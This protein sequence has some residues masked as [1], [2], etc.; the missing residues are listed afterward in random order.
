MTGLTY[1]S[2][3]SFEEDLDK[4]QEECRKKCRKY[5]TKIHKRHHNDTMEEPYQK[6]LKAS[7]AD[8]SPYLVREIDRKKE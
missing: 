1:H 3:L 6:Y 8:I 4:K 5:S 7:P 2:I